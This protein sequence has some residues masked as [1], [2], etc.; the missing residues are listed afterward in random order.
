MDF[1]NA[2]AIASRNNS[3]DSNPKDEFSAFRLRNCDHHEPKLPK[4]FYLN[5]FIHDLL[6]VVDIM[7]LQDYLTYHLDN[8]ENPM[9]FCKLL[10]LKVIP[11]M[12]S[13][14]EN[15]EVNW[16]GRNSDE[17]ELEDGFYELNNIITR[18][19]YSYSDMCHIAGFYQPRQELVKKIE[20]VELFLKNNYS[21]QSNF[22][23]LKWDGENSHLTYIISELVNQQF[24]DPPLKNGE[25][26][27]SELCRQIKNSF[28]LKK[29]LN[30]ESQR[31]FAS[32]NN[33]K[34]QDIEAKFKSEKF[35]IPNKKILS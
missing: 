1:K 26:N 9:I 23:R 7:E 2:L 8:V 4:D 6:F 22:N 10:D 31:R 16:N 32:P 15:A 3:E 11:T 29:T 21:A 33:D 27:Y 28:S 34:Y 24:I 20:E 25:I 19:G 35:Y 14:V 18:F 5:Y 30:V 12:K 13:V 17:I